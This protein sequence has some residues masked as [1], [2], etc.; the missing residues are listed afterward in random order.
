MKKLLLSLSVV[1]LLGTLASCSKDDDKPSKVFTA[2]VDGDDFSAE[3]IEGYLDDDVIYIYAEDG[4]LEFEIGIST[5]DVDAGDDVDLST[6]DAFIWYTNDDDSF[7]SFDG[8]LSVDVLTDSRFEGTFDNVE[9]EAFT[10]TDQIEA[11]DGVVK[12]EVEEF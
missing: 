12:T 3:D 8:E 6:G 2:E 5:D 9:M 4:D 10:T 11:T 7:F 1:A